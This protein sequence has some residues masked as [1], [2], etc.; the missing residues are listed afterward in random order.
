MKPSKVIIFAL[1]ATICLIWGSTWLAIK[2]GLEGVPPLLGAGLRFAMASSIFCVLIVSKG[3]SMRLQRK[4]FQVIVVVGSLN[5]EL[6]YGLVYFSEQYVSS[7][8]ASVLFSTYP[9]FVVLLAHCVYGLEDL[10]WRKV[11]GI[12]VG[13][14]GVVIIYADEM[15]ASANSLRGI[16]ALFAATVASSIS[17]V[18][19]KKHGREVNILV[20]NF[21]SMLLGAGLLFLAAVVLERQYTPEW[22]YKN[23][24]ALLDLAL[25]GSVVAFTIYFYLLKQLTASQMSYVT[26]IYPVL[27]LLLGS[28]LLHERFSDRIL[29]GASLVLGGIFISNRVVPAPASEVCE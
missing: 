4:S 7:G 19:L 6:S 8:L 26:L 5:F 17:L 14:F 25:F 2:L 13:F 18:H 1:Y 10:N 23:I 9:F 16:L 28:W 29:F 27:A 24:A 12:V 22:T 3:V 11:A 15:H 21:Y 20:L